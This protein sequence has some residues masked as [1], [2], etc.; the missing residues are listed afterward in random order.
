MNATYKTILSG[1]LEFGNPRS[2]EQVLKLYQHRTE[3]YYRNDI[4]LTSEE[5]F[6]EDSFIL[7]IPRFITECSEK[8][9]KNTLNL[10]EYMADYAVAGSLKAWVIQDG[11]IVEQRTIEPDGDKSATQAFIQARDLVKEK[12]ME[13]EAM[14]ALN[15]A[16][17][18]F[19][20]NALAYERRGY[21]NYRLRNFD[22]AMYDFTKSIDINPNMPDAYWGRANT[23]VKKNDIQGALADLDM[24]VARSIPHQPVYWSARRLKG[25][26][27]LRLS[28]FEKAIFELKL[29]TNRKF[30]EDDPNYKWQKNVLF[31]YGKALYEVGQYGDAVK[32]YNNMFSFDA[33]REEAPSKADQ[34]LSR[35]LARQ[36]AGESGYVNDFKEAAGL[37][38]KK[39]ADMLGAKA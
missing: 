38:S 30:T 1:C 34:F 14:N 4:L 35:G 6:Q 31:N 28:E 23:K 16:I 3:N 21:V 11:K 26:L 29:V 12:G 5:V 32:I 18:K 33:Q 7:T 19:E 22:D 13:E 37:G 17:E 36:K 15:R 25:E 20:R 24:A 9:W 2:Y 39:A 27:H 10:L 8:S